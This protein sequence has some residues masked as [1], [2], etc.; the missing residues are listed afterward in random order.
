M[1]RNSRMVFLHHNRNVPSILTKIAK[2]QSVS[3]ITKLGKFHS[4]IISYHIF[5]ERKETFN[6]YIHVCSIVLRQ[7]VAGVATIVIPIFPVQN[8]PFV[9]GLVMIR[10]RNPRVFPKLT[11]YDFPSIPLRL[12]RCRAIARFCNISRLVY[13]PISIVHHSIRGSYEPFLTITSDK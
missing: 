12:I 1:I 11:F 8:I 10:Q 7:Y 4:C 6:A 3:K 13:I 5:C 9:Y 2:I